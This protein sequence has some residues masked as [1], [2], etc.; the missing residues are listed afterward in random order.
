MVW[1]CLMDRCTEAHYVPL[2]VT[3]LDHTML[4]CFNENFSKS[5]HF[6][7]FCDINRVTFTT[8]PLAKASIKTAETWS[9]SHLQAS[10][11]TFFHIWQPGLPPCLGH[12]LFE[13]V[14]SCDL[15]LYISHLVMQKEFSYVPLNS[16]INH[17]CHLSSDANNKQSDVN[18]GSEKLSGHAVQN[19]FLL[20]LI[21]VFIGT[22]FTTKCTMMSGNWCCNSDK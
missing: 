16:H 3:T 7:R 15:A 12:D 1:S 8:T 14:V 11:L 18:P 17:F 21:P 6:C 10:N 22:R 13:G 2:L 20:R 4:C 5:T 9:Y 19:W